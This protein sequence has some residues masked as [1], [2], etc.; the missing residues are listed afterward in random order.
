M[1]SLI[2]SAAHTIFNYII[3]HKVP[4]QGCD[5]LLREGDEL[6]NTSGYCVAGC[7]QYAVTE[8]EGWEERELPACAVKQMCSWRAL[9]LSQL[10]NALGKGQDRSV[11]V[12]LVSYLWVMSHFECLD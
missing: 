3:V 1:K 8:S 10:P 2:C 7:V 11:L 12:F 4:P 9:L 6:H 5:R